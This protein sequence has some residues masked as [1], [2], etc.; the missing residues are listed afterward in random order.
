MFY[1]INSSLANTLD[2][3]P[4]KAATS[5]ETTLV[6]LLFKKGSEVCMFHSCFTL[7]NLAEHRCDAASAEN[8]LTLLYG[9]QETGMRSCNPVENFLDRRV[10][11]IV[12]PW[13]LY[14]VTSDFVEAAIIGATGVISG[15]IPPINPTNPECFHMYWHSNIFF[16]FAIDADLEKLWKKH[17]DGNSKTFSTSILLSSSDKVP[18]GR[19]GDG[20][21]LEDTETTQD[22]SPEA[23]L[24]EN[25]QAAYASA[26]NDLNDTKAYQEADVPG[27]YY[28]AMAIIDYRGHRVVAQSVLPG[29]LQGDKSDSLLYGSVDNI[30][31]ISWNEGF[32]AK[33]SEASKRLHL[34]EHSVLDGSRN[35]LKL[36]ARVEFKGIVGGDDRHYLLDLLRVTPR[37]ANYTGTSSRFCIL[38]PELIN[39]FCQDLTKEE[40]SGCKED[41]VFNPNVFTEFKLAG[42]PEEI[43]ADEENVRK[44]GQYLT[45]VALPKFVQDLCTLEVSPMDGQTS[46]EALAAHGINVRYIGKVAG[47]TKHL[48]HLRDLCNNEIVVRSAKH[49]IKVLLL[50]LCLATLVV[51]D[52]APSPQNPFV[53]FTHIPSPPPPHQQAP[54]KSPLPAPPPMK[55]PLPPPP[56]ASPPASSSFGGLG[57]AVLVIGVIA[58]FFVGYCCRIRH[59]GVEAAEEESIDENDLT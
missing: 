25:E 17:A 48:P 29:I 42:S 35:V 30:K 6:S 19:K 27:L 9:M 49:V 43:A 34:K 53:N 24:A 38:K 23:Q 52:Y 16:S 45:D 4:C 41:I 37:D 36:A 8:S 22:I 57:W 51:G 18:N 55:S 47:R 15:C 44:V 31:K 59:S 39:A 58:A 2:P 33:V 7:E 46:T 50:W 26:N 10:Y 21:S 1:V 56:Q 3:R 12:M 20:S 14:K 32:H 28:L 13:E 11:L 5:E 54:M 40:A